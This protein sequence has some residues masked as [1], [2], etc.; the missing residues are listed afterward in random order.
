MKR[1][2]RLI[3]WLF[4]LLI[5]PAGL[6]SAA[7]FTPAQ[8]DETFLGAL[9]DKCERLARE[10]E[11][12]RIIIA[13]GSGAAFGQD[14]ALL[15]SLVPGYDVVNFGMY[16]GLGTAVTLDLVWPDLRAG[17]VLI[18]SPEQSAQTL[19]MYFSARSMWQASDGAFA[20]L[21]R[22][23]A[24]DLSAMAGALADF[25]SD[26][27]Q[28][29]R[30]GKPVPEAV[31]SR[32]AFNAWGDV[33]APREGNVMPGGF[34]PDMPVRFDPAL[35]DADFAAFLRS[36][37]SR[38]E[39]RGVTF[40]YR[41]CPMN[42]A[43]VPPGEMAQPDAFAAHLA[44]ATGCR[45]LGDPAASVL[46]AGWFYDTNFHLNTA[47]ARLNTIR[48]AQDL[49]AFL[50]LPA[51]AAELP[52]MPAMA[53]AAPAEGDNSDAACFLYAQEGNALRLTGLTDE[54]CA[55]ETLTLPAAVDG[56]PV[57]SLAPDVFAGNARIR[58]ITIQGGIA[59]LEN[60]SFAGC[61]GLERIILLHESPADCPVGS[62]LLEGTD[63]IVCVPQEHLSA[64]L[65]NYFWAV[66][67]E[68]L[69]GAGDEPS[70]PSPEPEAEPEPAACTIRYDGNG[71]LTW[72]GE[73]VIDLPADNVH[74]RVNTAP[75]T[76]HFT[77]EGHVLTGWNT[78]ANGSGDAIGLGSRTDR[79]DGLT[80]YAQ[81]AACAPETDFAFEIDR[82]EAH[83]TAYLGTA[84]DVVVPAALGGA[85][86]TRI[87]T[88]AFAGAAIDRVIL[89][90]TIFSVERGAFSGSTL[91]EI[92]L[93]DNLYYIYDAS[94]EGC[95]SL[96]TLRINAA[97]LPVY[98]GTY[99]DT[100]ADKYD[101]L[102]SIRDQ[103]KIVLFSGSSGRYGYDSPAIHA[104]FPEY[105]VANMGVYAY[106]NAL[107][108]YDLIAD[109]MQQGDILL[110]APEFDTTDDQFCETDRLDPHFFAMMESN[111]DAL[112]LLDLRDYTA[113]FDS[114]G[115]YLTTRSVMGSRSYAVSPNGLDDDGNAYP[116]DT[117]NVEG[118]LILP[119]DGAPEDVL[120]QSYRAE[121]T[122]A[123]FPPALIERLNAA[124]RPFLDKGVRVYFSYTPR[125]WSS[126]SADSTPEERAR[127]H[128]HL[129]EYLCVPVISDIED[130]LYPATEFYLID[131]HLSSEGVKKLTTQI[132]RD[133]TAQFEREKLPE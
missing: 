18:F 96:T 129:Q 50:G 9:R 75:G 128:A 81:W 109:L 8:Y 43:A 19:S 21:N 106:T 17:D 37:A 115:K 20:M 83:I 76:R 99:F 11:R 27:L 131:S 111:Y 3:A 25:A 57:V 54:G 82:N 38:C 53:V 16:A 78:A 7:L 74:L 101:W 69:R 44:A 51:P 41:F 68:R 72:L 65:T 46:E 127:L 12:P 102:L 125:N 107:P 126:L 91:R 133:L 93:F 94:F 122:V 31:F 55:R 86:V 88:G 98:S 30:T 52:G 62:G 104:A 10:G 85:K 124:Y 35:L 40:L 63:A 130:Y 110:S 90:D 100:F 132:I 84:A 1:G 114:L 112:A 121:Y 123:A 24:D 116:F 118:D 13:G 80:L 120:L 28:C 71:G 14:S 48:L 22:L 117:Y 6:L 5:I 39:A 77:R 45:I 67:A 59:R 47:G 87:C 103:R 36:Y 92:T 2:M 4:V 56:L 89:P 49:C 15:E 113:V 29:L 60:G 26:K 61:T 108:Q 105:Q 73:A 79:A 23:R 70:A 95:G 34:D 42:A 66:H 32:A 119:R 64:W 58:Q 97:T 33:A